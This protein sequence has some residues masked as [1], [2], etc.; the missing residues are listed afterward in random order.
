MNQHI[1]Q[2]CL[3][4]DL[5]GLELYALRLSTFLAP[6]VNLT[7]I[8]SEA[9][10]LKG[11]FDKA[12]VPC[13]PIRKP[14]KLWP[15]HAARI[16][17]GIIDEED[18]DVIHIHWTK[19]IP[20]AVLAKLLS[21]KK[22]KLVQSR[23]MTMTRFKGDVYHKFLYKHMDMMIAVTRQVQEQIEAYVPAD[24]RP[25]VETHYIGAKTPQ[26]IDEGQ[27]QALRAQYALG[28]SFT[29]GVVA[30][31]EEGKG[32]YLLIDAIKQLKK[33]GMDVKALLVGDAMTDLYLEDLKA[34]LKRDGLE[35][36]IVF[37]GFITNVQELMQTCDVVVLPPEEET[38]GMVLIEAMKCGVPVIGSNRGG[39]LEIIEDGR[40][41]LLFESLDSRD[42]ADKI[43]Y[44]YTHGEE[45]D[46][47]AREGC[48]RASDCFDE[49]AQFQEMLDVLTSM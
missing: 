41:G 49:E 8:V 21:R 11:A 16:I 42:L 28:T 27:K 15:F 7:C 17:A 46:Q 39:P 33:Q 14:P 18:I 19:D 13:I 32:Q 10:R 9:G 3:S 37:T 45:R 34:G 22:P 36:N 35:S 30:R 24:V 44:L 43:G 6:E 20:L 5:G 1:L 4:P 12:G 2:L 48:K 29:V 47:M 38:F 23:H 40:S 31:I 25:N 26:P